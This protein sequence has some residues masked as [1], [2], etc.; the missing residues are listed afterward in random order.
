MKKKSDS[1]LKLKKYKDRKIKEID[2]IINLN[3]NKKPVIVINISRKK[4]LKKFIIGMILV[5]VFLLIIFG[6][7][8]AFNVLKVLSPTEITN[9][10]NHNIENDRWEI[11]NQK[12]AILSFANSKKDTKE[13]KQTNSYIYYQKIANNNYTFIELTYILKNE[14]NNY[15]YIN[16]LL[17]N[18]YNNNYFPGTIH[19]WNITYSRIIFVFNKFNIEKI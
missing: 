11:N 9:T 4:F 13:T 10:I 5:I 16:I 18:I 19:F 2:D 1:K 6:I 8:F 12:I 14:I 17:T 7:V 15:T 3:K